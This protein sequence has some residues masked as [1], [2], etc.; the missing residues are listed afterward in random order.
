MDAKAV[1]QIHDL[2]YLGDVGLIKHHTYRAV[3]TGRYVP[4]VVAD[5]VEYRPAAGHDIR[6]RGTTGIQANGEVVN[7]V[8]YQTIVKSPTGAT[9]G[10]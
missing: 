3:R 10:R 6:R 2:R 1:G 8:T 4:N 7:T 5:S 9:I